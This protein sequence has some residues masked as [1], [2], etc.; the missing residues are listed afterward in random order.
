MTGAPAARALRMWMAEGAVPVCSSQVFS[1]QARTKSTRSSADV[2]R[3]RCVFVD[4][5]VAGCDLRAHSADV[6]SFQ[7][8][9][10]QSEPVCQLEPICSHISIICRYEF[11]VNAVFFARCACYRRTR[12]RIGHSRSSSDGTVPATWRGPAAGRAGPPRRGQPAL[13]STSAHSP[14]SPAMGHRLTGR[15][16]QPSVRG[17]SATEILFRSPVRPR[18]G[19]QT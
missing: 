8:S 15:S 12:L 3:G 14:L 2:Y 9:P 17:R 19:L 6:L 13:R 4:A 16:G 18:A 10:A 7:P 11:P 5:V 1:K